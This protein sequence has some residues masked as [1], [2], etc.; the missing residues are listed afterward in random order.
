MRN[1]LNM[2]QSWGQ[3][4]HKICTTCAAIMGLSTHPSTA[5]GGDV[6]KPSEKALVYTMVIPMLIHRLNPGFVSVSSRVVPTIH[7]TYKESDKSKIFNSL[8][9][10]I[11]P[12]NAQQTT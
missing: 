11:P 1:S 6:H 4:V 5:R 12:V 8:F 7:S 9:L 3:T 10:Y 2:S